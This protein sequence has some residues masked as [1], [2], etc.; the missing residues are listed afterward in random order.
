VLLV[1]NKTG[2]LLSWLHF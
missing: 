1:A 2:K